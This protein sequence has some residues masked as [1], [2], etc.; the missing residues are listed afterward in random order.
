[1]TG[2]A[3]HLPTFGVKRGPGQC[4]LQDEAPESSTPQGE[5]AAGLLED[6]VGP[7]PC[8][9]VQGALCSPCV[10]PNHLHFHTRS[11]PGR[12]RAILWVLPLFKHPKT[13]HLQLLPAPALLFALVLIPQELPGLEP[14]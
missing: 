1:M 14:R 10:T 9:N 13:S 4:Q 5:A 8:S 12:T 7:H 11:T 3:C 6:L 2:T